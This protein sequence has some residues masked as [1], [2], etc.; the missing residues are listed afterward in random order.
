MKCKYK[1]PAMICDSCVYQGLN[2]NNQLVC[3]R[4]TQ[5]TY[6]VCVSGITACQGYDEMFV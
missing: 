1:Q 3:L 5:L 4:T 2:S 6:P